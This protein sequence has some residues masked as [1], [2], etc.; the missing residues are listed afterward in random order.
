M[1]KLVYLFILGCVVTGF[2]GCFSCDQDFIDYDASNLSKLVISGQTLFAASGSDLVTFDV[3]DSSLPLERRRRTFDFNPR[4][5]V[6]NEDFV[7]L[8][9]F[10]G[11]RGYNLETNNLETHPISVQDFCPNGG[12]ALHEML[13]ININSLCSIR[14][15]ELGIGLYNI[16]DLNS[17]VLRDFIALPNPQAVLVDGPWLFV[18]SATLGLSVYDISVSPPVLKQLLPDFSGGELSHTE[19]KLLLVDVDQLHQFEYNIA[20]DTIG[21]L[22]TINFN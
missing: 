7:F 22:S 15:E 14:A 2:F 21:F 5:L 1:R 12:I 17:I 16:D 10:D 18:S 20:N 19:G 4:D 6:G 3:S 13:L 8:R 11:W 9:S